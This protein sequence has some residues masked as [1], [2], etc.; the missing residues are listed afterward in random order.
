LK[1]NSRLTGEPLLRAVEKESWDPAV[2]ALTQFPSVLDYLAKN[3]DWTSALGEA[4]A[5]QQQDVMAAIQRMRAKAYEAGNPK[6]GPQINVVQESPQTI[7]IQPSN[8][9]VVY[10]PA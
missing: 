1:Q 4:A 8:S 3:L 9:Q 7:I 2:K 10:V 6:S 5:T